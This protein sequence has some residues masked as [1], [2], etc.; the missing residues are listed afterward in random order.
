M[1]EAQKLEDS[2]LVSELLLGYLPADQFQVDSWQTF[3]KFMSYAVELLTI[4]FLNL[5]K[6]GYI[7]IIGA[8]RKTI[9]LL[10]FT[11]PLHKDYLI[12]LKSK[13]S[14]GVI[15]GRL[16]EKLIE[17]L[18][19]SDQVKLSSL[20]FVTLQDI[21]ES[22]RNF[23]NP[24][25]MLVLRT[26][27]HQQLDLYKFSQD[28]NWFTN[29]VTVIFNYDRDHPVGYRRHR[30]EDFASTEVDIKLVMKIARTQLGKF[31][32]AD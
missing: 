30:I 24:G 22:D 19:S 31:Q 5:V 8:H 18:I 29:R 11:I 2:L 7:H 16:E 15:M 12:R 26:L 27:Q 23:T 14:N 1:P 3:D 17:H 9:K 25:K 28:K 6:T 13:P 32:S 21:Y 20:L 10:G 4:S